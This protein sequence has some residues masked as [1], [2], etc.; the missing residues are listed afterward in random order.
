M[1]MLGNVKI[2]LVCRFCQMTAARQRS[3]VKTAASSFMPSLGSTTPFMAI[4]PLLPG[5][6]QDSCDLQILSEAY[7]NAV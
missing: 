4:L 2:A 3:C 5:C 6:Q 7:S 1:P